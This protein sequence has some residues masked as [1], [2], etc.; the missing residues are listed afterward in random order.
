MRIQA[1][2]VVALSVAVLIAGV[3]LF[4]DAGPEAGTVPVDMATDATG[5]TGQAGASTAAAIACPAPLP[6]QESF[7]SRGLFTYGAVVF[8]ASPAIPGFVSPVGD[9]AVLE[10]EVVTCREEVVVPMDCERTGAVIVEEITLTIENIELDG[11]S[12]RGLGLRLNESPAA[13]S[14]G[15]VGPDG[16]TLTCSVDG[17]TG[18]LVVAFA[19]AVDSFF[20]IR[21]EVDVEGEPFEGELRLEGP[22]CGFPSGPV[23]TCQPAKPHHAPKY[24]NIVLKRGMTAGV[25]PPTLLGVGGFCMLLHFVEEPAPTPCGVALGQDRDGFHRPGRVP[26]VVAELSDRTIVGVETLSIASSKPILEA[27]QVGEWADDDGNGAWGTEL[28]VMKDP[29]VEGVGEVRVEYMV[30][31]DSGRTVVGV[32]AN[33]SCLNECVDGLLRPGPV[34]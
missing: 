21:V 24:S 14:T 30:T 3:P 32:I 7:D 4:G 6:V 27:R 22:V 29:T 15:I 23:E 31:Y 16:I 33:V 10:G 19:R 1:Q 12:D 11:V 34:V 25:D 20:D 26:L 8:P 13:P 18:D 2:A 28:V 5:A 9:A 17:A